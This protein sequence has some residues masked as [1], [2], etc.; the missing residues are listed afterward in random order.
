[1]ITALPTGT[2]EEC[3]SCGGSAQIRIKISERKAQAL[4]F[5]LCPF[6]CGCLLGVCWEVPR[7]LG[8]AVKGEKA[9]GEKTKE[10]FDRPFRAWSN[11]QRKKQGEKKQGEKK[12][13]IEPFGR[14]VAAR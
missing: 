7:M 4:S 8:G 6:C 12:Q 11:E 3:D 5:R 13:S 9:G 1:M 10:S 14:R 2:N